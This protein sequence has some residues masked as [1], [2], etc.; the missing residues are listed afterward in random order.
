MKVQ[1]WCMAMEASPSFVRYR[2]YETGR[3][4][5]WS[6]LPILLPRANPRVDGSLLLGTGVAQPLAHQ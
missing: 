3:D 2:K 1:S 4:G 6:P 5:G